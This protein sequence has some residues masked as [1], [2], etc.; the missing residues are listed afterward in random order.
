MSTDP[1]ARV[2]SALREYVDSI[3]VPDAPFVTRP[4]RKWFPVA[5]RWLTPVTVGLAVLVAVGVGL[6][7]PRPDE[8]SPADWLPTVV[9]QQKGDVPL[10]PGN[11]GVGRGSVAYRSC[12]DVTTIGCTGY[13]VMEDGTHYRLGGP[14]EAYAGNQGSLTLSPD[15]RWLG[16][17]HRDEYVLRDLTGTTIRRYPGR[18]LS[19]LAWSSDGRWLVVGRY[20][21]PKRGELPWRIDLRTGAAVEVPLPPDVPASQTFASN[22]LDVTRAGEVLFID[23]HNPVRDDC[24]RADPCESATRKIMLVD[25]TRGDQPRWTGTL[26]LREA[27]RAGELAWPVR[28]APD[29]DSLLVGVGVVQDQDPGQPREIVV[30]GDLLLVDL[31]TGRPVRRYDIK[32]GTPMVLGTPEPG[33]PAQVVRPGTDRLVFSSETGGVLIRSEDQDNAWLDLL[34]LATGKERTVTR[35]APGLPLIAVRGGI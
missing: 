29:E 17:T 3:P 30:T 32:D 4:S 1:E 16:E 6:I 14:H 31:K 18:F 33:Q 34:D 9:E 13:L 2:R 27:L 25:P 5:L 11:R 19:A 23:N 22:V 7:V 15:G 28:L 24:P 12:Q 20:P 8:S 10:L 35:A 21:R 26:R